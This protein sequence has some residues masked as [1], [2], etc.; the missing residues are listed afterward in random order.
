MEKRWQKIARDWTEQELIPLEPDWP[1]DEVEVPPDLLKRLRLRARELGISSVKVPKE[2][3]GE[4]LPSTAVALV[5]EEVNKSIL[6]R[7]DFQII[8]WGP[9][10]AL[11]EGTDYLKEKYL[12]P[13]IRRE[14]T[15]CFAFTEPEH[16]SDL[17]AL[18]TVA[19]R[20]GD[21]YIINGKKTLIGSG[22]TADY[23]IVYASTNRV[24]GYRGVTAF[25]VDRENNPGFKITR[26]RDT[27]GFGAKAEITFDN[28]V[29]PVANR[30]GEEGQGF[31]IGQRELNAN[32][33]L[34]GALMLGYAGRCFELA[35]EYAKKRVTFGKPLVEH[36]AIQWMLVDSAIDI[37]SMRWMVYHA[38]WKWDQGE[39][40]RVETAMVKKFCPEVAQ[41]VIDR[42]LQIFGG[43]GY[44]KDTVI[45]RF[46]RMVRCARIAEG[47]DE[48]MRRIIA[49]QMLKG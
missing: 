6:G 35:K 17:A 28:C 29:V 22:H 26:L 1:E 7:P 37:E 24:E 48:M 45:E 23:A 41:R 10:P 32:R 40:I 9:H 47:T 14:K 8:G 4:G 42:A 49:K 15:Y 3:G 31:Y 43:T 34:T 20:D 33:V 18:E 12:Y 25:L 38:A 19:V 16:G 27:M 44:T 46:Y 2:Y 39:D 30:L 11:Y 36:Q 21:N 13:V 5:Y